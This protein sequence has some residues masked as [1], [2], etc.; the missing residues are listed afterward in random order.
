MQKSKNE[1]GSFSKYSE[2]NILDQIMGIGD[3]K[4][5]FGNDF[6]EP[7][8]GG[9]STFITGSLNENNN[10]INY[11]IKPSIFEEDK[12]NSENNK[13]K[14]IDLN[15]DLNKNNKEE[16]INEDDDDNFDDFDAEE[17]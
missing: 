13:D 7:K 8:F 1:Y 17:I 10:N 11:N 6:S 12:R 15:K 4:Q 5:G 14:D 16:K 9:G 2:V 3:K